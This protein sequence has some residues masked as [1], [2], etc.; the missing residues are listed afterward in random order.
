MKLESSPKLDSKTCQKSN[1]KS[2][3]PKIQRAKTSDSKKLTNSQKSKIKSFIRTIP[4]SIALASALSSQA[5]AA[6]SGSGA[7]CSG[8]TCTVTNGSG[9]LRYS[10]GGNGSNLTIANTATLR[11]TSD[12]STG[13][14]AFNAIIGINGGASAGVITNN[15]AIIGGSN[16]TRILSMQNTASIEAI[17][18]AGLIQATYTN[19]EIKGSIGSFVN[20]GTGTIT[21]AA[22]GNMWR[23][24]I[25]YLETPTSKV[26]DISFEGS[27]LTSA[28][29]NNNLG[30]IVFVTKD[31]NGEVIK[32]ITAKDNADLEGNFAFDTG[33]IGNITFQDSANMTGNISLA[34]SAKI[35]NGI[36]IGGNSSGGSGSDASVTGNISLAG[37]SSISKILIDGSNMGGS[38]AN[39]T[40]KLDGDITL[41]TGQ[42]ITD[43]ITIANGGTLDGNINAQNSS[44][45]GGIAINNGSLI[46]NILLTNNARIQNGIVLDSANMTGNISLSTANSG[47]N[48]TIDSINIGNGSTMTGD[49]SLVGNS[50]ITDSITIAGILDG[51]VRA[52]YGRGGGNGTINQMDISGE[53]TKKVQLDND[54]KISTLNLNGGTITGGIAFQGAITNGDTATIDNL[55]LNSNAHIGSI[56]I[57]NTT[58][59]SQAKGVISNLTLN[60]TSSIGTITNN[61]TQTLL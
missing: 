23:R 32:S 8:D 44:S 61:S 12:S 51:N 14:G 7:T 24:S 17:I 57:G 59:G 28:K 42:G 37:Q 52:T 13:D 55:T 10:N 21:N 47:G 9:I 18:N 41:T 50:K 5:V 31:A 38:G 27:S 56:D 58:S 25:L 33:T 30:N 40:P 4:I 6:W 36:T 53:I 26:G 48:I 60:D 22:S 35:T 29:T 15:G 3:S 54:S 45:I 11:V 19:F 16:Q 34:N 1:S 2:K 20:Q 49:I 46:G 39:G 43:G